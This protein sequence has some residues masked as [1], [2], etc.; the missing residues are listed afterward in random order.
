MPE[1]IQA[2]TIVGTKLADGAV[3]LSFQDANGGIRFESVIANADFTSLNTTVNGGSTG[4]T[5][6]LTYGEN[7]RKGDYDVAAERT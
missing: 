5:V 2:V 4:A 7:V 3:K 1:S 6:T